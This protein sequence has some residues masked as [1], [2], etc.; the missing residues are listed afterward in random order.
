M[1]NIAAATAFNAETGVRGILL[2]DSGVRSVQQTLSRIA[3]SPVPGLSSNE[4]NSLASIGISVFNDGTL[5]IDASKLDN[6]L[7]TDID[8]VAKVFATVGTASSTKIEYLSAGANTQ[9][10]TYAVNITQA[11]EQAYVESN[12]DFT[13]PLAATE[14]LTITI[15]SV[16]HL[17]SVAAGLTLDQAVDSINSQLQSKGLSITATNEANRLRLST[18]AYGSSASISVV[19]DQSGASADQLGIGTTV[20]NDTGLDVTGTIGGQGAKGVGQTLKG[21]VGTKTEGLE[22]LISA[23]E[24]GFV[25]NITFS[26][27]VGIQLESTLESL[28]DPENGLLTSRVDGIDASIKD[29]DE[30]VENLEERIQAEGARLRAQFGSLEIL[31]SQFQSTSTFL[32]NQLSQLAA[33]NAQRAN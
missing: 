25:G 2:G 5:S 16:N 10:G 7:A 1:K 3:T 6:A 30:Q 22:L 27:G 9:P 31:L 12:Q 15:G 24:A 8:S 18:E 29:L 32:T 26:S 21:G 17:I 20:R 14:T 19:S 13:G 23:T 33:I 4:I 28:T 11:A